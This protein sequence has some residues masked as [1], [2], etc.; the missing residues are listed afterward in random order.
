ML[1]SGF[2]AEVAGGWQD[3]GLMTVRMLYLS[4]IRLIGW[5]VR[6]LGSFAGAV[7]AGPPALEAGRRATT[8]S[9]WPGGVLPAPP[10]PLAYWVDRISAAAVVA[11]VVPGACPPPGWRAAQAA[12]WRKP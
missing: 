12:R 10:P 11:P 3:H 4:L 1:T 5:M 9:S 7:R 6:V 2:P 8:S